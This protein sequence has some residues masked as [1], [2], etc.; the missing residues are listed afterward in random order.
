[1]STLA[2]AA[3]CPPAALLTPWDVLA[4]HSTPFSRR[5]GPYSAEQSLLCSPVGCCNIAQLYYPFAPSVS[6]HV[7]THLGHG[8]G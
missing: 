1:M 4:F 5:L 7:W 3:W 8:V 2:R 6:A